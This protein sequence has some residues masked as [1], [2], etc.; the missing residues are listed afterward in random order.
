MSM[1]APWAAA[2][3]TIQ[4]YTAA[5]VVFNT[6]SRHDLSDPGSQRSKPRM[7]KCGEPDCGDQH[8]LH[9]LLDADSGQYTTVLPRG[10]AVGASGQC[11]DR[12]AH[13]AAGRR[14]RSAASRQRRADDRGLFFDGCHTKLRAT[15][16][17]K[18]GKADDE[19]IAVQIKLR[20]P[21]SAP[22]P[23]RW[24]PDN[25]SGAGLLPRGR[26]PERGLV[27]PWQL[28]SCGARRFRHG[29]PGG[30][31][32]VWRDQSDFATSGITG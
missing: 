26:G 21:G 19:H 6:V 28:L 23:T 4:I 20:L 17:C 10:F 3:N 14:A 9:E 1:A 15:L 22:R 16:M 8:R 25:N 11:R 32:V 31:G 29:E 27:F 2:T 13:L 7:A 12:F 24:R 18:K 5:D 30:G